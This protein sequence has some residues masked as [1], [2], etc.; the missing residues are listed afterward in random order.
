MKK[1]FL[2][3]NVL[4]AL[5]TFASVAAIFMEH[6]C[7]E[8]EDI[9]F[10]MNQNYVCIKVDREERPD[11]DQIYMNVI[12]LMTQNGGWPMSVFLTPDQLPIFAGTYS[13][14]L[15]ASNAQKKPPSLAVISCN[16]QSKIPQP[17]SLKKSS[18]VT[19]KTSK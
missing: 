9:A 7:F 1:L 4:F 6:E 16:T 15:S 2:P 14:S 10:T 5:I 13:P 18:F 11:I 12:Q 17:T 19:W 3:R 8:N